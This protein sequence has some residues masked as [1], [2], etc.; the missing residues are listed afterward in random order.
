MEPVLGLLFVA[1]VLWAG[2]HAAEYVAGEFRKSRARHAE[3]R[4]RHGRRRHA[5]AWWTREARHGFPVTR[6]GFS[7]GWQAHQTAMEQARA[8]REENRT[9]HMEARASVAEELRLHW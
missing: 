8:R 5:V 2:K 9:S 3:T 4:G 7:E 6:A 1:G